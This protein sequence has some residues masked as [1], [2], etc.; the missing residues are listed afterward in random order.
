RAPSRRAAGVLQRRRGTRSARLSNPACYF[1]VCCP[2]Q[3]AKRTESSQSSP[4]DL[5]A[6]RAIRV[7]PLCTA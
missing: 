3:A 6:A 1:S 7:L 5:A 4:P 2:P